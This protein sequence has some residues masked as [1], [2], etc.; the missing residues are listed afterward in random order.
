MKLIV[1]ADDY[2]ITMRVSEGII[3]GMKQGLITDTS[4]LVNSVHFEQSSAMALEAGITAMGVHLNLTFM[5]PVLQASAVQS[6]VDESGRFYRKPGLIP[7]SYNPG[8]VRAELKAQIEKFLASG[9]TL[10][11]LDTHHGVSVKDAQMHD[12]VI[13]LAREYNV[14][15]RRDD[16]LS[17]ELEGRLVD[18]GVRSTDI[19]CVDPAMPSLQECWFRSVLEQYKDTECIV[20]IAGHPGYADGELRSISSLADEREHD[21]ALLM[22]PALREYVRQ[23]GIQL[24]SYSQL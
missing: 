21:L 12:L 6:I 14:P 7:T 20:E 16:I 18:A 15:M 22:N 13:E 19:L 2:G 8:E 9:L 17:P 4:A 24:I 23:Q 3:L 5:T 1:N 11:H 10:N